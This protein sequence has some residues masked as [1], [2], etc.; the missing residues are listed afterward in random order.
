MFQGLPSCCSSFVSSLVTFFLFAAPYLCSYFLSR[1]KWCLFIVCLDWAD[2]KRT[3]KC[4]WNWRESNRYQR[5][6]LFAAAVL[7]RTFHSLVLFS[8]KKLWEEEDWCHSHVSTLHMKPQRQ[9][10][11]ISLAQLDQHLFK[12]LKKV[13]LFLYCHIISSLDLGLCAVKQEQSIR[14]KKKSC[15]W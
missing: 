7:R 15:C 3:V 12:A 5:C 10:S 2:M 6:F 14:G 8:N 9:F 1:R 11:V 4:H 13:E